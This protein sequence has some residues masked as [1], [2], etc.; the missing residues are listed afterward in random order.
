MKKVNLSFCLSGVNP[1]P[2][3]QLADYSAF[4][5][6]RHINMND[7]YIQIKLP[8]GKFALAESLLVTPFIQMFEDSRIV[9]VEG[10]PLCHR[11]YG[12]LIEAK[13]VA[14]INV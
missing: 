10:D 4:V 13:D 3:S 2:F 11:L 12:S 7:P 6:D 9:S 14:S 5:L 1:R 8:G